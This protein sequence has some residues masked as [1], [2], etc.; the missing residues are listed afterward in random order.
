M[1]ERHRH[2]YEVNPDKISEIENAGLR[3]VGK[4]D[5]GKRMEIVE[6]KG[7]N[8]SD[9]MLCMILDCVR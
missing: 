6:L 5:T 1:S 7:N 2:R 3:F 4:D 9:E 8:N